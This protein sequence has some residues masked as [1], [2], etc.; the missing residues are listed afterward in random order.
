MI[1]L[2]TRNGFLFYIFLLR[3]NLPAVVLP[4]GGVDLE[5]HLEERRRRYM[6]EAMNR[7]GQVQTRAAEL[8]GMTFRSF[9]YFAKKYGL[10]TRDNGGIP[11][12]E[13]QVAPVPA[14]AGD[15]K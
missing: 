5:Q 1:C 6:Q 13:D 10:T 12:T 15:E 8:L 7:C 9:R 4:E 2:L 3:Q 14:M 11:E